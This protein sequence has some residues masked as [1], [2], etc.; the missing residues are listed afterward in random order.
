M[1]PLDILLHLS[2]FVAPALAVALVVALMARLIFSRQAAGL[3]W[4]T[5]AAINLIVGVVVLAAG[6]WYFGVDGKMVTYAAMVLAVGSS[7]WA[8]S[9]GWRG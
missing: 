6:A 7:Q 5:S 2:S 9:R 3:A 1:G 4:W 8:S